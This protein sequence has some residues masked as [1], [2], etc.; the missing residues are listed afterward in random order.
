[1]ELGPPWTQ[2]PEPSRQRPQEA[3]RG[4]P[5]RFIFNDPTLRDVFQS[6]E[7]GDQVC[8]EFNDST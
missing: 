2:D 8:E 5:T 4:V 3:K 7:I 6:D 1:M